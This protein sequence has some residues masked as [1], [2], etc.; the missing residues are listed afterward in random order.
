MI[1]LFNILWLQALLI[2]LSVMALP[3]SV[4]DLPTDARVWENRSNQPDADYQEM[5]G[6][7]IAFIDQD[8]GGW[9]FQ[10]SNGLW[11]LFH[12]GDTLD[13]S[14]SYDPNLEAFGYEVVS[15]TAFFDNGSATNYQMQ[16]HGPSG[17]LITEH[18][19]QFNP[20]DFV[21]L[22]GVKNKQAYFNVKTGQWWPASPE[23][24]EPLSQAITGPY[25]PVSLP[26]DVVPTPLTTTANLTF[27]TGSLR[28]LNSNGTVAGFHPSLASSFKRWNNQADMPCSGYEAYPGA[29]VVYVQGIWYHVEGESAFRPFYEGRYLDFS[30]QYGHEFL[31]ISLTNNSGIADQGSLEQQNIFLDG[32]TGQ[33]VDADFQPLDPSHYN[34]TSEQ[35]ECELSYSIDLNEQLFFQGVT[36]YQQT[37]TVGE[38]SERESLSF[39]PISRKVTL[40]QVVPLQH[41]ENDPFNERTLVSTLNGTRSIQIISPTP[42]PSPS[43]S[44]CPLN[45]PLAMVAALPDGAPLANYIGVNALGTQV[46]AGLMINPSEQIISISNPLSATQGVVTI[47]AGYTY[48]SGSA[49]GFVNEGTN[50]TY[51]IRRNSD[52]SEFE[53]SFTFSAEVVFDDLGIVINSLSGKLCV[54]GGPV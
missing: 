44:S 53:I 12:E 36:D 52:A 47:P 49:L 30:D 20:H 21:L 13:L 2:P 37:A 16:V 41:I 11:R 48:V 42:S 33:L 9:Y 34:S 3:D 22:K 6:P 5:A 23:L 26:S 18:G 24:G 28:Y 1:K 38:D 32:V 25:Q 50:L 39:K 40:L 7:N 46:D 4:T 51:L 27:D 45:T 8:K 54:S 43:P 10:E 35:L 31:E 19:L 14:N 17:E 15:G 29:D